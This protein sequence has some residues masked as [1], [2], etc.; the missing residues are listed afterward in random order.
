MKLNK[1]GCFCKLSD[2]GYHPEGQ[3][4]GDEDECQVAGTPVSCETL[5]QK[6]PDCGTIKLTQTKVVRQKFKADIGNPHQGSE[7]KS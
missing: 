7:A 1:F 5:I 4:K 2:F 3:N 6:A